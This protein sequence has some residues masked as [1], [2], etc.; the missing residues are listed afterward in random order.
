[1]HTCGKARDYQNCDL[2]F[3]DKVR[4]GRT[5]CAKGLHI[6]QHLPAPLALLAAHLYVRVLFKWTLLR[7]SQV[8]HAAGARGVRTMPALTSIR[9]SDGK[10]EIVNQLL[11]PHT[12]EFLEIKSI[13]D[14]YDAIK[15]M[16]VCAHAT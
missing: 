16:K 1:M 2:R 13:D 12:T 9:T 4:A 10:L 15:S 5:C 8:Q 3:R 14:A 6:T 7:S 11:L